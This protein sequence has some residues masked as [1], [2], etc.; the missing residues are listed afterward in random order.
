MR[1]FAKSLNLIINYSILLSLVYL[2]KLSIA[3]Q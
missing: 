1:L 2:T 3:L